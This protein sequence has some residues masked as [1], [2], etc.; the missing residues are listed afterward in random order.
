M[1]QDRIIGGT[2]IFDAEFIKSAV[3]VK[4]IPDDGLPQVAFL[5]RSNV[6]KSSLLNALL[7]EK[8]LVKVSTK[9]GKT[10]EMNFFLVNDAFYFVDLPGVG[11]AQVS[12]GKRDEMGDFIREYVETCKRLKGLVYMVDIRHGGHDIDVQTVEAIRA[13]GCPV[14]LIANKRDKVNQSELVRNRKELQAKFSLPELPIAVSAFKKTGL[15][16][17]WSEILSSIAEQNGK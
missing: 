15:D 2:K 9:P 4:D 11:Y 1:K 6:G 10:R 17:L 8:S 7:G 14:L 3:S 12:I 5:G 13:G 16:L